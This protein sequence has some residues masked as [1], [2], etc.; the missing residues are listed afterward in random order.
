M[1]GGLLGGII[2]GLG[3]GG[4][5]NNSGPGSVNIGQSIGDRGMGLRDPMQQG[6][7][8]PYVTS[9]GLLPPASQRQD[10]PPAQYAPMAYQTAPPDQGG[11]MGPSGL[12]G[13]MGGI[14]NPINPMGFFGPLGP[15]ALVVGGGGSGLFGGSDGIAGGFSNMFGGEGS[16]AY[17]KGTGAALGLL[18]PMPLAGSA[19]GAYTGKNR[20]TGAD[21]R[22]EA[23]ARAANR[24]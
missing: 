4:G 10:I 22:A 6:P 19:L 13:A 1:L 9:Q 17:T 3:G 11:V 18:T 23:A 21:T 8:Q 14:M 24:G 2:P 12:T 5:A 20:D 7:M 15:A 16:G